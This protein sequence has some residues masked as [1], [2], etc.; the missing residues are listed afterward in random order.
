MKKPTYICSTL[1]QNKMDKL[2]Q[3]FTAEELQ[4]IEGG[5]DKYLELVEDIKTTKD[6]ADID[7]FRHLY[8]YG[9][10]GLGKSTLVNQI[11]RVAGN[12]VE[13][14][15]SGTSMFH[16][17]IRCCELK[18]KYGSKKIYI[19]V[20]DCNELFSKEENVNIM[21]KVLF[22]DRVFHYDKR[23]K[24]SLNMLSESTKEAVTAFLTPGQGFIVPMDTF[25]FIFASNRRL[26]IERTIRS[27]MDQH[28]FAIRNKIQVHDMIMDPDTKWGYIA[29]VALTSNLE[30]VPDL[31]KV[32][33]I[34]FMREHWTQIE[35]HSLNLFYKMLQDYRHNSNG[36]KTKWLRYVK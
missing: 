17:G 26:P 6:F 11:L 13:T 25:C 32:D 10:S 15:D 20:D 33:A 36:Y 31:V 21:K 5:K 3:L 4:H 2:K 9:P 29:Y 18:Q 35:S 1:N 19:W 30:K 22:D 23:I 24:N 14:V 7:K 8:I 12:V 28:R 27:G 34:K 16:F